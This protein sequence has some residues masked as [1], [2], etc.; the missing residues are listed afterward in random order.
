MDR[1][2]GLKIVQSGE[3]KTE[4]DNA[5]RNCLPIKVRGLFPETAFP[6]DFFYPFFKQ[7]KNIVELERLFAKGQIYGDEI[8]IFIKNQSITA[9]YL[10][11][12]DEDVFT[13]YFNT[14][15]KKL[16]KSSEIQPERKT[17][18][19]YDN[20][21]QIVQKVFRERPNH[22]NIAMGHEFAK[23][24]AAH[25]STDNVSSNALFSLF[26]KDYH[27]FTHSVQVA[28]LGMSFCKFLGWKMER[29]ADFGLGA[30]FHDIGKNCIDEDIL[31]KPGRLDEDE[32]EIVKKHP[33]MGFQQ[34]RQTETM[35][36]EQL[37]V[38]L[39][40]HEAMDGSGYPSHLKAH[41]IHKYA[42]VARIVDIYDALTTRRVYKDAVPPSNALQIM[43]REM[44]E[45]LDLSLLQAFIKFLTEGNETGQ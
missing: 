44:K 28:L 10:K 24:F 19:L 17:E 38:V 43:I 4:F 37:F 12:S 27:T 3:F 36:R 33:M 25:I 21:E 2:F 11:Q 8:R 31:N 5:V 6:C 15:L 7:S 14:N 30:L 42:R 40:H 20:A 29:V 23:N 13:D 22:S 35:S 16:L 32:F 26:A 9:I 41:Q 1:L 39:Q 18:L 45:G 34:I